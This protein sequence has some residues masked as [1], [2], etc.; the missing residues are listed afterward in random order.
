MRK[1]GKKIREYN[2]CVLT[3]EEQYTYSRIYLKDAP[4]NRD[5]F[6]KVIKSILGQIPNGVVTEKDGVYLEGLGYFFVFMTP[7]P[8]SFKFNRGKRINTL[9]RK[10]L[11]MFTPASPSHFLADY[12]T[13]YNSLINREIKKRTNNGQRYLFNPIL[14]YNHFATKKIPS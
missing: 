14:V 3:R 7:K 13:E 11:F 10:N 8:Y 2:Y 5:N 6:K 12:T 1:Y 4:R 9:G